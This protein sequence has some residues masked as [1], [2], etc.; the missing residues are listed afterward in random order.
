MLLGLNSSFTPEILH[1]GKFLLRQMEEDK[2]PLHIGVMN[3]YAR[4]LARFGEDGEA[5]SYIESR[6]IMYSHGLSD[7][8]PEE[9]TYRYILEEYWKKGD[10][11][12]AHL[13]FQRLKA[14]GDDRPDFR[15]SEKSYAVS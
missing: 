12:R 1:Y 5:E 4:L 14:L 9:N 8:R 11:H 7:V 6:E 10:V 3:Q 2:I 13:L 15:P